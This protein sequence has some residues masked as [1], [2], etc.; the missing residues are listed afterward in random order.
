MNP[1]YTYPICV[2]YGNLNYDVSL[3]GS[4]DCDLAAPPN[5]PVTLLRSGTITDIST[6]TWGK[7]VCLKLDQPVNGVAYM[8]YL[9]LSAVSPS[10]HLNDHVEQ[11]TLIGWVGGANSAS[12]Y[13]GTSNPTGMNFLNTP[14]MSSRVQVGIALMR[15]P[16]YGEGGGWD[17]IDSSLDPMPL[18]V[19]AA[20]AWKSNPWATPFQEQNWKDMWGTAY[21]QTTGIALWHADEY[22]DGR[23]HGP[24][25]DAEAL[26]FTDRGQS[27][28]RQKF[29]GGF[30]LDQ[31]GSKTWYPYQ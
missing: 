5:C 8:A 31:G 16:V 29:A 26:A 27:V 12:Q 30:V 9:H 3:G 2:P 19:A 21:P 17:P 7:Q 11:G 25:T 22:R 1:Y 28:I 24:P 4:H 13:E 14:L 18:I 6:P 20:A 23:F 15:G 10:I